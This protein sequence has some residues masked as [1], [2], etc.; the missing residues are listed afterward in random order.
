MIHN[1]RTIPRRRY[2]GIYRKTKYK[3]QNPEK[4][5]HDKNNIT[6]ETFNIFLE[7]KFQKIIYFLN[8]NTFNMHAI[9][10]EKSKK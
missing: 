10:V 2:P 7:Y 8:P 4:W 9:G 5:L 6:K 3:I 1:R